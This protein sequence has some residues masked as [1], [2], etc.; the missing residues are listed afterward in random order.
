MKLSPGVRNLSNNSYKSPPLPDL[1]WVGRDNDRCIKDKFKIVGKIVA[2][3]L[4]VVI[5]ILQVVCTCRINFLNVLYMLTML[6][7]QCIIRLLV[8][9]KHTT[10]ITHYNCNY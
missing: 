2:N 5:S 3:I 1:G 10:F 7:L 9:L 4:H 6:P 8:M